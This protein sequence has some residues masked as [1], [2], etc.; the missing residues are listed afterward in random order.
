[1]TPS[2]G[3]FPPDS[4]GAEISGVDPW[5]S[6]RAMPGVPPSAPPSPS[7]A[8]WAESFQ[9]AYHHHQ[10]GE[11]AAALGLYD[12]VLADRPTHADAL[13]LS[14]LVCY[15]LGR[16]SDALSLYYRAIAVQPVF[17][18]A[19]INLGTALDA[20]G[21][22]AG[23]I[24]QFRQATHQDPHRPEAHYNLG[25]MYLK[26]LQA[27]DD[28]G[29]DAGRDRRLRVLKG[30][31]PDPLELQAAFAH[32]CAQQAELGEAVTALQRAIALRS[33]YT[34]AIATLGIA[35]LEW[36]R[37]MGA[38]AVLRFRLQERAAP[39]QDA[40]IPV[41]EPPLAL[42][43]AAALAQQQF[44]LDRRCTQ[45]AAARGRHCL[46]T[47]LAQEPHHPIASNALA[48]ACY[49]QGELERAIALYRTA[50]GHTTGPAA[51]H[52]WI[53]LGC[54]LRDVGRLD[55][56]AI[57][58]D[59]ALGLLPHAPAALWQRA[60]NRLMA[61]DW[62]TGFADY[63]WR[64][65]GEALAE[66]PF[67]QPLWDGHTA[68]TVLCYAEQGFGDSIQFVRYAAIA[69]QRGATVILDCPR[70]LVRLLRTAPGVAQ[71][72]PMG[73]RLPP[74][75]FRAPLMSLPWICGTTLPTV[76][77]TIPYLHA[78]APTALLT[79]PP[80]PRTKI[81]LVW[82]DAPKLNT[83]QSDRGTDLI[84]FAPLVAHSPHQW[85]SLQKGFATRE[86]ATVPW[87]SQVWAAGDHCQDFADTAAV[88]A[89]LDLVITV[90]TAVAHLAGAIGKPVWIVLPF[91]P[92][93]RW[94]RDRPDTPWYPTA[95]LFRHPAPGD[96][97]G[98][99]A[100]LQTALSA[101]DVG[102][103]CWASIE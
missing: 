21:D 46:A 51:G 28:S 80:S 94:L 53:N 12:Q 20:I 65:L 35:W 3:E 75:D 37:L 69:A 90:D 60:L 45:D 67:R 70:S 17:A 47:A 92:D 38:I 49:E 23:A 18:L 7:A 83:R 33:D 25:R 42:L 2:P 14:G 19:R 11:L 100:Q 74:C 98:A 82:A 5:R 96:W 84:T 97:A 63:E 81:G 50:L 52:L 73:D 79:L 61:G 29:M 87:G 78:P 102:H 76:P 16:T 66:R 89:Q 68:G 54:A 36:S 32:T 43:S 59:H 9:R 13:H 72:V 40:R 4:L 48:T 62:G 24:A 64:W 41:T 15:Q 6:R 27:A 56:A 31:N 95:R 22:V 103:E 55:E 88:I 58:F 26:R 86:L 99:I 91:T 57:A 39:Y 34:L 10:Q 77:A 8:P 85:V 1:M 71:V 101:V 30:P 44:D 93:W